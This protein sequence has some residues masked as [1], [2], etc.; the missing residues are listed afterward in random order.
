MKN[1][2]KLTLL[3]SNDMH[4]DFLAEKIDQDL[5]GGV[6]LLSGYVSKVRHEEENV[7]YA[8]AGDMFRGSIIDS[9]FQGIST[10]Q[11]M[12]MLAPDVATVG[13]HEIDYGISHL[14]FLEKCAEFPIINANLHLRTNNAR[15]FEPCYVAKIGGM[16]ILFIGIITD[17]IIAQCKMDKLIG[18]FIT[19]EDAVEEIGRICDTYNAIDVDL[20]VLLTHI[21]F[22]EDQK[23]AAMLKP[24]WGIDLI[25]GGHSHTFLKEP[26]VVNGVP[27]VQVG[28]GTDEIGRFDMLIDTDENRIESFGWEAVPINEK[29]CPK[30]QAIEEIINNYK[31]ST[32]EKYG[33]IITKF[34]RQLTHPTRIQE[35]ELGDLYADTLKDALGLDIFLLGSGSIRTEQLGP[36]VTKRDFDENFPYHDSVYLTYWT[37]AQLKHGILHMLRDEA[38]DEG[39][40]EFYQFS[41]GLYVEYDQTSHSFIRFEF[42]GEPVEDDRVLTVGLEKFHY[43]NTKES[44]DIDLS[45]LDENHPSREVATDCRKVLEEMLQRG[46]HQDVSAGERL[47]IHLF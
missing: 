7:L 9:E 40:T 39:Y 2:K 10:I 37:G 6:S 25:I 5:V 21:G 38:L 16:K 42:Q 13:N 30:D 17:A 35:T 45:E 44:F 36:V 14:L 29:T 1:L 47:I 26:C 22:E 34:V 41:R 19:L 27:I 31:S 20:T 4:G 12:N 28:T 11:I 33:R 23:L 8:I 43:S 18:T 3:H 32:D 46:Q 15:L 24:A